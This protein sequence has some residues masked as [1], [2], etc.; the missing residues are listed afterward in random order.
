MPDLFLSTVKGEKELDVC[1]YWI[2]RC[3]GLYANSSRRNRPGASRGSLSTYRA[4]P[5]AVWGSL[6]EY[7]GV[8]RMYVR[9]LIINLGFLNDD[10]EFGSFWMLIINLEVSDTK[11]G[12]K[13]NLCN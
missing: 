10:Y 12:L 13:L 1:M 8:L 4:F 3:W 6:D 2:M 5:V 7:H 11:D 9:M